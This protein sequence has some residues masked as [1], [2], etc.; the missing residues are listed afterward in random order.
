M[1]YSSQFIAK[2]ILKKFPGLLSIRT[3]TF[4]SIYI[5][6][7]KTRAFYSLKNYISLC[8]I[9]NSIR[10]KMVKQKR[11]M[12]V[13]NKYGGCRR[14]FLPYTSTC[15]D[16]KSSHLNEPYPINFPIRCLM[17]SHLISAIIEIDKV[18][19]QSHS[20]I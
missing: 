3:R 19:T 4:V 14:L 9:F 1:L 7:I 2:K 5:R 18:C 20:I 13:V 10:R 15:F 8:P 17:L 6:F 12:T 11:Q 16:R